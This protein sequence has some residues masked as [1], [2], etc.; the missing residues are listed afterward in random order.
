ME[1]G[2]VRCSRSCPASDHFWIRR[3]RH[4]RRAADRDGARY[5]VCS[6]SHPRAGRMAGLVAAQ[7]MSIY[8]S[9]ARPTRPRRRCHERTEP[10]VPRHVARQKTGQMI[11]SQNGN[12]GRPLFPKS[13]LPFSLCFGKSPCF[14]KKTGTHARNQAMYGSTPL[15]I[16]SLTLMWDLRCLSLGAFDGFPASVPPPSAR[17]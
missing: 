15:C 9:R 14:R 17:L 10:L 5:R 8:G 3:H 1:T 6:P 13:H 7:F 4:R 2:G 11:R 12:N 16:E